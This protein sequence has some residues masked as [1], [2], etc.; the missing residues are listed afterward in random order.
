MKNP[1]KTGPLLYVEDDENDIF[2]VQM[3][4]NKVGF[5]HL[6]RTARSGPEAV[7][8][9]SGVGSYANSD[10]HPRPGLLL[11]DLNLPALSGLEVL[12]WVRAQPR[13]H[14]LPVVIFSASIRPDD[15]RRALQLGADDYLEKPSS[16]MK[17]L[18]V[19]GRL[20]EKW[21]A[22]FAAGPSGL[23]AR[24]PGQPGLLSSSPAA[25]SVHHL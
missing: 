24:P 18:N 14:S 2:F 16:P 6:L 1:C 13:F 8:Y 25:R 4:F 12:Q 23:P 3:A 22:L 7:D 9:L 17:F 10:L 19:L 15:Q 5:G 20:A 21:P 11:L